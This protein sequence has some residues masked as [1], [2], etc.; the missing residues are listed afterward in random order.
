MIS[1]EKTN[2]SCVH[3]E[4]SEDFDW[5]HWEF[6]ENWDESIEDRCKCTLIWLVHCM[7]SKMLWFDVT[8]SL[9]FVR[10]PGFQCFRRLR[11]RYLTCAFYFDV[12]YFAHEI[13]MHLQAE[14]NEIRK[15]WSEDREQMREWWLNSKR[16]WR[17]IADIHLTGRALTFRCT[18]EQDELIEWNKI[19]KARF[20]WWS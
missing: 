13:Y 1:L 2:L 11:G 8:R 6:W 20:Y 16:R 18:S 19:R 17:Q 14:W 15:F 12:L 7:K 5:I 10:L 9:F 3:V 4:G